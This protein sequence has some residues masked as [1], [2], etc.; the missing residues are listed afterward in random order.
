MKGFGVLTGLEDYCYYG[1]KAILFLLTASSRSKIL[2][3]MLRP[4]PLQHIHF[5]T[6]SVGAGKDGMDQAVLGYDQ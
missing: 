1:A 4:R 6:T 5:F 2:S 3:W